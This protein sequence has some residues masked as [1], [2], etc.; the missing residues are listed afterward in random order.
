MTDGRCA[1]EARD[2]RDGRTF[3]QNAQP[4]THQQATR[5]RSRNLN[6]TTHNFDILIVGYGPSGATFATLMAKRGYSVAVVEQADAIYDKPRAITADQE[7]MRIFQE[8]GLAEEISASTTP[9]PGTDFVGLQGQI[10]KRF[11]P[12]PP[13][14]RLAWEPTW[15]FVQPQLEATIRRGLERMAGV[16]VFLGHQCLSVVQDDSLVRARVR[17]LTDGMEIELTGNYLIGADGG[18]SAVRRAIGSTIEDL[19]FDEWWMVVDAWIRR[20]IELPERCVQYCRPSRPGTYIVGPDNLRR[21]EI[22]LLPGET[23]EDFANDEAVLAVLRDFVDTDPLELC[24]TAIYRFHA[25][26]A[27]VWRQDRV[28]LMGDA[29]H[30]MPPFLGQGL[31]AGIRDA[32][33]LAWKLDGVERLGFSASLLDTYGEE[34]KQ[35]VRTVVAHAKSFGLIIGELDHE[36]ARVRDQKL[37]DEIR[38]GTAVTVRQKFIPMLETGLVARDASGQLALGAGEL[39]VQ[40]WVFNAGGEHRLDDLVQ[41]V[42]MLVSN[43]AAALEWL[44]A[45]QAMAWKQ[46]GGTKL[47]VSSEPPLSAASDLLTLQERD[48]LLAS[49]L[50]EMNARVLVVR[51]DRYVFGAAGSPD[52]LRDV[53]RQLF[54]SLLSRSPEIESAAATA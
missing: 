39:F 10:I 20:P 2:S 52:E 30:Q 22:K 12:A 46:L 36:A 47:L 7:V 32:V 53:L 51:P 49:Q 1:A 28:F 17:R 5:A 4:I 43:E 42:F 41:P 33:N 45:V 3:V 6:M 24:R 37:E 13:P 18:R 27:N 11:Y 34:R 29:A 25:L 23:P 15:M 54:A 8:C 31:C 21:W 48:G 26:V 35:H 44:D 50:A 16:H 38:S 40:P 14:H 19:A 9:H